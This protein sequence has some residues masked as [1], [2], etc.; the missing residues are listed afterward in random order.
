MDEAENERKQAE[1]ANKE[2]IN[3]KKEIKKELDAALE[4]LEKNRY[5]SDKIINEDKKINK[6]IEKL[7]GDITNLDDPMKNNKL[8]KDKILRKLQDLEIE[9]DEKNDT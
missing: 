9:I 2:F 7:R 4:D 1:Q 5:A 8:E 6:Q 3:K